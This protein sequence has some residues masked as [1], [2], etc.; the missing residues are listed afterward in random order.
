MTFSFKN[1]SLEF[2][3][4]D[5]EFERI[6]NVYGSDGKARLVPLKGLRIERTKMTGSHD[7][8]LAIVSDMSDVTSLDGNIVITEYIEG[9]CTLSAPSRIVSIN[10]VKSSSAGETVVTITGRTVIDR[11]EDRCSVVCTKGNVDI[12]GTIGSDV[13]LLVLDGILTIQGKVVESYAAWQSAQIP[14]V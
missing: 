3:G 8:I 4:G 5:V 13:T 10:T 7:T 1:S 2:V 9:T 12:K 14:S 11:I 6:G